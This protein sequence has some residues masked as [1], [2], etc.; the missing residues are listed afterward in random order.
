MISD[1]S[2]RVQASAVRFGAL[3]MEQVLEGACRLISS[4]PLLSQDAASLDVCV[5]SPNAAAARDAAQASFDRKLSNHRNVILELRNKGIHCRP[6]GWA[7]TPCRH[8]NPAIRS[9]HCF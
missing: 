6:L 5:A 7:T 4:L 3:Q 2:F 1:N 9:R 8:S